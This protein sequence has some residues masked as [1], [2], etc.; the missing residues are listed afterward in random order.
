MVE[1]DHIVTQ[2]PALNHAQRR[3]AERMRMATRVE[4]LRRAREEVKAQ[5]RREGR[6]R[7]SQV[8]PREITAMAEAYVLAH[9]EIIVEARARVEQWRVEGFFGKT[10]QNLQH[11]SKFA[12]ACGALAFIE[13]M[14]CTEWSG[15]MIVGYS[16]VSTDGQTRYAQQAALRDTEVV[17]VFAPPREDFL[18]ADTRLTCVH[19]VP[20][21]VERSMREKV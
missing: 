2:T 6:I 21:H 19:I 9:R 14:S 16:R 3:A 1:A 18:A 13:R 5:I 8:P 7:L 15:E 20:R 17:D 4:A 10:A 11:L 12:K